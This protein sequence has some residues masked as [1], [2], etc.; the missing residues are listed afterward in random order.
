MENSSAIISMVSGTSII[1][2]VLSGLI[3]LLLPI[4]LAIYICVKKKASFLAVA[5]GALVF[6]VT[7]MMLRIP[8]LNFFAGQ[9]WYKS[10]ASNTLMIALFL[11]LTAGLFEEIGRFIG[12]RFP[13]KSKLTWENGVAFG[14]GHGGIEAILLMTMTS[15][16]NVIYSIMINTGVYDSTIAPHLPEATAQMI[17]NQLVNTASFTF[18]VGGIERVFAIII[19]I[20]FSLLVLYG[21]KK[22]AFKYVIL[23]I[24]LHAVVDSPVVILMS[25]GVNIWLI[26]GYVLLW[27]IAS[28]YFIIKSKDYFNKNFALDGD[29][30]SNLK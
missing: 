26:E 3:S 16:N 27:A 29:V 30:S 5:I 25:K 14:I 9:D 17:K 23:A 18:A 24:I 19:Q 20:G 28:M 21:V 10:M 2:M 7:Q 4:G 6:V 1:F 22:R 15:I 12:F 8:L 13:L 11:G